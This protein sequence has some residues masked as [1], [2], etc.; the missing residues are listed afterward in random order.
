MCILMCLSLNVYQQSFIITFNS[1]SLFF[2]SFWFH[3]FSWLFSPIHTFFFSSICWREKKG[4]FLLLS[5]LKILI[6]THERNALLS[7]I[8]LV[9]CLLK[10]KCVEKFTLNNSMCEWG[11]YTTRE[12]LYFDSKFGYK[13]DRFLFFYFV[14]GFHVFVHC[15]LLCG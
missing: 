9:V 10:I 8:I 6:H 5:T 11:A 14:K 3:S 1:F 12:K 7:C 15:R 4:A 13:F 2:F